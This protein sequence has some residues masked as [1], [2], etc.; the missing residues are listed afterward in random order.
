MV[1][2]SCIDRQTSAASIVEKQSN[3][4]VLARM[5]YGLQQSENL[6][7][8]LY[9]LGEKGPIKFEPRDLVNLWTPKGAVTWG[10]TIAYDQFA[11]CIRLV[12]RDNRK[13]S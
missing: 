3:F 1:L 10:F 12:S 13:Q 11:T 4:D 5:L 8:E 6:N 7:Y 9:K 2:I